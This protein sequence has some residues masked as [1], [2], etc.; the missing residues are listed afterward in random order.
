MKKNILIS[1]FI[2][3]SLNA[4]GQN[5]G[6]VD[7]DYI[8]NH[9]PEYKSALSQLDGLSKQWQKQV[10]EN[11]D[12]VDKMYKAY[13]TDQ[14]LLTDESRKRREAEILDKENV[15]KEFQKSKFGPDGELFKMRTNLLKPIQQKVSNAVADIAKSKY[16]DFVFDKSSETGMMI[17]A[18]SSYDLS[19]EV[20]LKMGYKVEVLEKVIENK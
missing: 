13:Q 6:F 15:A 18:N 10:E 9:M 11:F 20:I 8:L 12:A 5:F 16:K 17:Y 3:F 1:A 19:N 4:F 2:I 7:T 14:I